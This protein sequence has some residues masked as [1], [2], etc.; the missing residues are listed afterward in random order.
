M[1][2]VIQK[3]NYVVARIAISEANLEQ[4]DEFKNALIRLINEGHKNIVVSFEKVSYV[5][6]SFLGALVSVLKY[7]MSQ[8]SDVAVALLNKDIHN[9][10][11][12]I[13][14]DKVF[15]I[16]EELPETV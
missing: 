4:A 10:F 12:M 16:H 1:I 6:S 2:D 7:A 8:K 3:A 13:R 5:D 15:K 9:L 11:R 14:M